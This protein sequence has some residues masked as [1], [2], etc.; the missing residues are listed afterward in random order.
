MAAEVW[1]MEEFTV[2][3][4]DET[5]AWLESIAVAQKKTI[6]EIIGE[7]LERD[8]GSSRAVERTPA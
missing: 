2:E 6:S 5:A 7:M 1:H 3:L 8:R 4:D